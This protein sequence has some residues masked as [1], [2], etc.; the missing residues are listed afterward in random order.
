VPKR[1]L[2]ETS[3]QRIFEV[4]VVGIVAADA[5]NVTPE[6]LHAEDA[7]NLAEFDR[8]GSIP[9]REKEYLHKDGT[10]IPVLVGGARLNPNFTLGLVVDLTER[11]RTETK[12]SAQTKVI[13][14]V[15]EAIIQSGRI[16]AWSFGTAGRKRSSGGGLT[17]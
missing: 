1:E 8:A 4:G 11:K 17:K 16:G 13:E 2:F 3:L 15:N 9:L 10:R 6:E 12:L 7:V 14:A 5:G